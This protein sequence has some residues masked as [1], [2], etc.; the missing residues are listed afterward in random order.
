MIT[1]NIDVEFNRDCVLTVTDDTGFKTTNST[2]FVPEAGTRSGQNDYKIS[3]GYFLDVIVYHK[4]NC[5]W[6]V[7]NP[8]TQKIHIQ[9]PLS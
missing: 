2:G 6:Q 7:V 4:Y 3:D 1:L 5:D 8:N 9:S